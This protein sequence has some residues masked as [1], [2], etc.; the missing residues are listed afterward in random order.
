MEYIH[1]YFRAVACDIHGAEMAEFGKADCIGI[2]V[3]E[4][5][6]QWSGWDQLYSIR[7]YFVTHDLDG[8]PVYTVAYEEFVKPQVVLN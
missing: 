4:A 6:D 7:V 2:A 1:E 8:E 3:D 5:L